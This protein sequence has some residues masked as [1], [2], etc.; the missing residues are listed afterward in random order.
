[1][2][3]AKDTQ[4]EHPRSTAEAVLSS[5]CEAVLRAVLSMRAACVVCCEAKALP[6]NVVGLDLR[7]SIGTGGLRF[8]TAA[9]VIPF[10]PFTA[11]H[12]LAILA[13][14]SGEG[15]SALLPR[16]ARKRVC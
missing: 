7:Q 16:N 14:C 8:Q 11:G 13:S 9:I 12:L 2:Q 1:M 5:S 15:V 6:A 4:Q 10:A 3:Q